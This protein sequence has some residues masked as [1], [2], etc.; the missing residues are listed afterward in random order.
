MVPGKHLAENKQLTK[1]SH[2]FCTSP[3]FIFISF[4]FKGKEGLP[5]AWQGQG[6][7]G[8]QFGVQPRLVF[9]GGLLVYSQTLTSNHSTDKRK[10][11]S[12]ES[13][14]GTSK[15][16]VLFQFFILEKLGL[17]RLMSFDST[18]SFQ[19]ELCIFI[20]HH[21]YLHFLQSESST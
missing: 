17:Q 18:L 10:Q 5:P 11:E 3:D 19:F 16:N 20:K 21:F 9:N 4:R 14:R 2:L 15:T 12:R 6:F 8:R 7:P 1:N 13:N